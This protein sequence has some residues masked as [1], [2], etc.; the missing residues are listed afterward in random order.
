MLKKLAP[1]AISTLCSLASLL[2]ACAQGNS[3]DMHSLIAAG[4]TP[5]YG[6][7]SY[8]VSSPAYAA[9]STDY[10]VNST[11]YSVTQGNYSGVQLNQNR[12]NTTYK[13]GQGSKG[14]LYPQSSMQTRTQI[15]G[16]LTVVSTGGLAPVFG[17]TAGDIAA[18]NSGT[19][20]GGGGANP[21]ANPDDSATNTAAAGVASTSDGASASMGGGAPVA[22][23]DPV[24]SITDRVTAQPSSGSGF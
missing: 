19:T 20:S 13:T 12:G 24:Q 14:S 1:L 7:S 17:P 3:F 8:A 15:P 6:G 18:A 4:M 9:S 23:A 10:A 11:A 21:G 16:T 5:R 22:S 2:P